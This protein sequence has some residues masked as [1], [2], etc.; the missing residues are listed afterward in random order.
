MK[1][2]TCNGKGR[3]VPGVWFSASLGVTKPGRGDHW[4]SRR[5]SL[6]YVTSLAKG[7]SNRQWWTGVQE[8]LPALVHQL[9]NGEKTLVGTFLGYYAEEDDRGIG[10]ARE[11]WDET[12]G[13]WRLE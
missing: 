12:S 7:W 8:P 2:S 3:V 11:V 13:R 5:K 1:C 4:Y 6:D 9:E 10:K